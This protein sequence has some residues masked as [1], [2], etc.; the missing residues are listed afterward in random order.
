M[1]ALSKLFA[2]ME[3]HVYKLGADKLWLGY[4]ELIFLGHKLANGTIVPDPDA[5][6]AIA[7][8]LAPTTKSEVRAFLGI[9]GYYR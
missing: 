6:K 1:V 4:K 7:E 5:T 8:L 3:T 9:C 2:V